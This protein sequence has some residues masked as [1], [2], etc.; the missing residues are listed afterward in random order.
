VTGLGGLLIPFTSF[1][2]SPDGKT[3]ASGSG[4]QT[5]KLWN[6][7][8]GKLLSTLQG[9]TDSVY[10]VAWSPEGK[11]LASANGDKTVKLWEAATGKLLSTLHGHTGQV[12]SVAWSPDGKILASGSDDQTVKLWDAAAGKLL[13]SFPGNTAVWS[14]AW[15]PDGE[16]LASGSGDQTVK[17]WDAATGKLLSTLQGH[18]DAVYSVAWSSD[19]K[20]LASANGDRT[21]K[22]WEASSTF[23]IDL[24]EYLSS[25]WIRLVGSEIVWEV[26]GNLLRDRAFDVVNLRGTTLLG[27]NAA[28]QS[29]RKKCRKNCLCCCAPAT[30]LK[31]SQFGRP[32][33]RELPIPLSARCSLPPFQHPQRTTSS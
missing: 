13:T 27:M 20:T 15:S 8:T 22:L 29:T 21:V 14:V 10:S 2:W 25:R 4:D 1:G 3:L 9:H 17:L 18:T 31:R 19:G 30:S 26:N 28:V 12:R 33:R 6:A 11:I 32:H 7:A 23:E 16:T 5:V 24:A